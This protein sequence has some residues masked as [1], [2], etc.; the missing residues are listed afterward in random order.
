MV[1]IFV[2]TTDI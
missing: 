2:A 1:Q